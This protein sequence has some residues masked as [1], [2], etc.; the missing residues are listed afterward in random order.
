M[1]IW[2]NINKISIIR[3]SMFFILMIFIFCPEIC[4]GINFFG[5]IIDANSLTV[6]INKGKIDSVQDN[7]NF[8]VFSDSN[9]VIAKI[10]VYKVYDIFSFANIIETSNEI[11]IKKG[12]KISFDSGDIIEKA[13]QNQ[14]IQTLYNDKKYIELKNLCEEI[15]RSDANNIEANIML[16][17]SLFYLEKYENSS[18]LCDELLKFNSA[19]QELIEY[20]IMNNFKLKKY[21]KSL[22]IVENI[23]NLVEREIIKNA[24]EIYGIFDKYESEKIETKEINSLLE[25]YNKIDDKKVEK[26][27]YYLIYLLSGSKINYMNNNFLLADQYNEKLKKLNSNFENDISY[28]KCKLELAIINK[29]ENDV[30]TYLKA[31]ANLGRKDIEKYYNG[32][33]LLCQI[34]DFK[35]NVTFNRDFTIKENEIIKNAIDSFIIAYKNSKPKSN[36]YKDSLNFLTKLSYVIKEYDQCIEYA[37][38]YLVSEKNSAIY[39]YEYLSYRNLK[40]YEEA[41]LNINKAITLDLDSKKYYFEKGILC[42]DLKQYDKAIDAFSEFKMR[43]KNNYIIYLNLAACYNSKKDH[44]NALTNLNEGLNNISDNSQKAQ[45]CM[46]IANTYVILEDFNKTVEFLEKVTRY[47]P[48]EYFIYYLIGY[49]DMTKL[50]KLDEAEIYL[51]KSLELKKTSLTYYWLGHYY[52]NKG[53]YEEAIKCFEFAISEKYDKLDSIKKNDAVI[54]LEKA[55][56]KKD[57]YFP[58]IY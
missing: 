32:L 54:L 26:S 2:N 21:N 53:I 47:E 14:K 49:Y 55:K 30:N 41:L 6:K 8:K 31:V 48:E 7:D 35:M 24:A 13:K 22:E 1:T 40:K 42:S 18:Y 9:E 46:A 37:D 38:K 50:N 52:F 28:L 27:S 17:K 44:N 58:W 33:Y 45:L 20:S 29:N 36:L 4:Y 39:F 25:I 57:S 23:E 10:N 34:N 51:K 56:K 43:D 5:E 16:M 12:N 3:Q 15:L 11:I 19:N